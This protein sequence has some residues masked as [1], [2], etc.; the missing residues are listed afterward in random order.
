VNGLR[1][2]VSFTK[3][4]IKFQILYV[5]TFFIKSTK[6]IFVSVLSLH[7]NPQGI[8]ENLNNPKGSINRFVFSSSVYFGIMGASVLS[9]MGKCSKHLL[10]LYK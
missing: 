8:S 2:S 1:F 4:V 3:N 6:E 5:T 7:L 9:G 10:T